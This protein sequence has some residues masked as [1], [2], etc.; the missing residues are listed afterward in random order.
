AV[1]L[2]DFTGDMP[3][4]L[5]PDGPSLG[6]FVCPGVLATAELWKMGQL[7]PGDRVRL[8]PLSVEQAT[9]L[10]VAQNTLIEQREADGPA[11]TLVAVAPADAVPS[12]LPETP[13]R[14]RVVYR[15]AGDRN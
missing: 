10:E 13:E 3:I 7:R 4:L 11:A 15:R 6:G 14:V 1:G 12:E 9:A 8:V 5:G 2:I